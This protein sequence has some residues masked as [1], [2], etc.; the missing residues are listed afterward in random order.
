MVPGE[1]ILIGD[2]VAKTRLGLTPGTMRTYGTYLTFLAKGW[3]A[4]AR[5]PRTSCYPGP[6]GPVGRRG[7]GRRPRGGAALGRPRGRSAPSAAPDVR[8]PSGGTSSPRPATAPSTTRSAP[9]GPCS[10]SPSRTATSPRVSTPPRR[11][12]S[13]SAERH[14]PA[15]RAGADE[16]DVGRRGEHRQRPGAGR[17]DL[18]DHP[19]RRRAPRRPDQPHARRHRPRGVHDPAHREGQEGDA[20]EEVDQPVPDWF[21]EELYRFAVSRGATRPSDQVLRTRGTAKTRRRTPITD[22]RLDYL[23]QRIQ[24]SLPW[25][26]RKQVT[27][28]VLRHHAI[29]VVQARVPARGRRSSSPGT[30]PRAPTTGTARPPPRRSPAPWS[31]ST[32][33]TT[34]GSTART[35]TRPV[36]PAGGRPKVRPARGSVSVGSQHSAVG[37]VSPGA[38]AA[39]QRLERD[40]RGRSLACIGRA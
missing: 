15:P 20:Q 19:H 26:D 32:A 25:A 14:P 2:L 35:S 18:P 31:R 9:G 3:P 13:P 12:T 38:G 36:R 6:R 27:A 7:A 17:A 24:T 16:P 29:A 10:T 40:A 37:P 34:P 33:A 4:K 28:H 23:F 1:R 30:S 21:V 8:E 5:R 11:S 39:Q 22:R